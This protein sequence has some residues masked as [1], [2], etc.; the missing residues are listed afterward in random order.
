MKIRS[1][2]GQKGG[3]RIQKD[4]ILNSKNRFLFHHQ[5][6]I[7]V[8]VFNCQTGGD[9]LREIQKIPIDSVRLNKWKRIS[10]LITK[11]RKIMYGWS[12]TPII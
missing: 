2:G 7:E 11:K 10:P 9:V 8:C 1:L 4:K 5:S 6:G 12:C 3:Y